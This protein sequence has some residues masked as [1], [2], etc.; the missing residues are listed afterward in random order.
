MFLHFEL[1]KPI[2]GVVIAK[3]VKSNSINFKENDIVTGNLPWQKNCNAT[4]NCI[5]KIDN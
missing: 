5:V 2:T 1:G 4:E 3:V